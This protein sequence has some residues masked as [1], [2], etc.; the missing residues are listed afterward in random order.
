MLGC[1]AIEKFREKCKISQFFRE[2]LHFFVKTKGSAT[3]RNFVK[4]L[5]KIAIICI[6]KKK[7]KFVKK[8][9]T[10]GAMIFPFAGNP[11]LQL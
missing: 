9:K 2:I 5:R 3:M 7:R 1:P 11:S 8:T 4:K 6:A 10:F